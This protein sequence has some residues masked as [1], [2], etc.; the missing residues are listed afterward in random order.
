MPVVVS[1]VAEG[2]CAYD[3]GIRTG[4]RIISVNGERIRDA[5]DFMFASQ[6]ALLEVVLEAPE[7]GRGEATLERRLG[8]PVGLTFDPI[9]PKRCSCN[10]IFCFVDQM[11]KGLRPSLYIKDEDFRLSF[12]FGNFITAA[13]LSEADFQRIEQ[14][15]LSPLYISVHATDERVR[16]RLIA[17]PSASPILPVLRRLAGMG[18]ELHTQIVLCPGINDG[19]V[20]LQTVQDLTGLFPAVRT[21]A[22]VPVGLTR[23]RDGLAVIEPVT[24]EYASALID[25]LRPVQ[26]ELARRSGQRVLFLSDEFYLMSG[27]D[28]PAAS[29]YG[30]F[31]QLENGVG[32]ASSFLADLTEGLSTAQLTRRELAGLAGLRGTLVTGELAAPVLESAIEQIN[33]SLGARLSLLVVNNDFFGRSVT[34]AGLLVGQDIGRAIGRVGCER[35]QTFILPDVALENE[36]ESHSGDSRRFIDGMSLGQ[37]KE[38]TGTTVLV[39]PVSGNDL[40]SFLRGLGSIPDRQ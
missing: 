8:E 26:L 14:Q 20:L 18:I 32:I 5:I 37:L 21:A 19:D 1:S 3:A 33:R 23:F 4:A 31:D 36:M 11:P 13:N 24:D 10:C 6:D 17:N 22:V 27:K 35:G 40:V 34:V 16:S 7:R 30:E 38:E 15:H 9:R 29:E 12:L 2:S 39:A 28:L 25:G